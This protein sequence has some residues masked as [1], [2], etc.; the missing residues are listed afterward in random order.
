MERGDN[1]GG[2]QAAE[3]EDPATGALG[4]LPSLRLLTGFEAAARLGSVSRAAEA[5]HL[6]QS[7]VSHQIQ[8]LEAFVGQPLFQRVGRGIELT[9]AGEMLQQSVRRA[10]D[11]LRRGLDRIAVYTDPGLVVLVGPAFLLHGWLQGRLD[12]LRAA[13]PDI[14]PLLSIDEEPGQADEIDVDIVIGRQP[15][16]TAGWEDA[17]W[18]REDW[19]FVA[20]PALAEQLAALPAERHP[21]L[22]RL[23][24]LEK[25][26]MPEEAEAAVRALSPR[27]GVAA[28]YDAPQLALD[29]ALRGHGIACLPSPALEEALAEGRLR[30]LAGYPRRPGAQ[31]WLSR[32]RDALRSEAMANLF[33]WLREE[34][35]GESAPL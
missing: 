11:T 18:L 6:S 25:T 7:A 8:Q 17:A 24:C 2:P 14:V 21:Q 31:W 16:A 5:L 29:A 26:R 23:I 34:G 19:R 12:R 35:G 20:A 13:H 27:F 22:A 10:L 33:D 30:E 28:V 4:R 9:F 15:M 32:P 1:S 3:R